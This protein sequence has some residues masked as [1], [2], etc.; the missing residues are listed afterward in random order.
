[1]ELVMVTN[2]SEFLLEGSVGWISSVPC[3]CSVATQSCYDKHRQ[4]TH[5]ELLPH[6][7]IFLIS[8][9]MSEIN[10]HCTWAVIITKHV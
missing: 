5:Q 8:V 4:D 1:M 3:T 10:L 2:E 7:K 9:T 6:S